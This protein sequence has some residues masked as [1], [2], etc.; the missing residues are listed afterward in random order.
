MDAGRRSIGSALGHPPFV[1]AAVVLL[2]ATVSTG[3]L[4]RHWRVALRKA[5]VP[6]RKPLAQFDKAAVAGYAF[7]GAPT[8]D[9]AVA[10]QMGATD[11][12]NWQFVDTS[13][14]ATR[15]PRRQVSCF[16]TYNT[17]RPDLV[18]HIPDNCYLGA[19]YQITE[20]ANL[21][22][23]LSGAAPGL[24]EVPVRAITFVKS[25]VFER[26]TPTV[27]YTFQCNGT[28]LNTR[29]QVRTRLGNPFDKGAYFCK[30]EVTFGG[31]DCVPRYCTRDETIEAA[32]K[33]L[34]QLLPVLLRD[35]LP[36]WAAVQT[37]EPTP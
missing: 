6:L 13:I 16:I 32:E 19:G 11:Y 18:P 21:T 7:R 5:P 9:E 37:D 3:P 33:F 30:V 2:A 15:D 34:S 8:L 24:Q 35:H 1:A 22:I 4:A 23:K 27:I 25:D 14:P 28:F 31:P 29:T 36:D 10:D 20:A 26:A 17:G 12:A